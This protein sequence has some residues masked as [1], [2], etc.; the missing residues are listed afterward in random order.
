MK[1]LTTFILLLCFAFPFMLT[2]QGML[3]EDARNCSTMEYF[4]LQKENDPLLEA[5]MEQIEQSTQRFVRDFDQN[6]RNTITIPVVVH[7]VYNT[8]AEN[9]SDAQILSQIEVLNEDFG[10]TNADRDNTWSQAANTNIQFCLASTDPNGNPTNGIT[11]TYN[12]KR[13]WGTDD[14]VKKSN[15]G[16]VDPW[17]PSS[18]LN[19]WVC[20]LGNGLLGYAQ[21]PGGNPATDGVVCLYSAFGRVGT[22]G[23]NYDLGRTTTHEVGHYL[24]LRHIWGDGGCS[25]DDYVSDTPESDG[26]NYGCA[27]GHVSCSSVDMYQNYMDYSYD[28]CMNL[29]TAGQSAR[30]QAC[31]AGPRAGLASSSA[32]CGDGGGPTTPTCTDG[33]QNGDETGVDCGGSACNACPPAGAC[34]APTNLVGTSRKGGREGRMS[35]DAVSAADS[36]NVRFRAAGAA[37][38]STTNTTN[39]TVDATGLSKGSSYEWGV[40]SVCGGDA[41]TW[42][43][44]SFTARFADTE[45]GFNL[46][47]NPARNQVNLEFTGVLADNIDVTIHDMLGRTVSATQVDGYNTSLDVSNLDNGVYLVRIVTNDGQSLVQKL[48][49]TK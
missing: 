49:I 44:A 32:A 13:S 8:S 17:D 24:N 11:R 20:N 23:A 38:W 3:V 35:W 26:A 48:M 15:R 47:P 2:A 12:K 14:S 43:S 10:R 31:L 22:L 1:K 25:V 19:M 37:T 4:E 16:G 45:L 46:F 5:R 40:Q 21:F 36:Y 6:S 29:F 41:S 42:A 7:V 30:M 39:T 34:D 27:A 28:V 9:I 33:V 18:Y